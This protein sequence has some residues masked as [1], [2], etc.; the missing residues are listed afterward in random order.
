[1]IKIVCSIIAID[2]E[3]PLRIAIS[4]VNWWL[5]IQSCVILT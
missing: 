2:V 5:S 3:T 4:H 1:M